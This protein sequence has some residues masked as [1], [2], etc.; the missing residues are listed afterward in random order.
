MAITFAKVLI[1]LF[2][3]FYVMYVLYLFITTRRKLSTIESRVNALE[4]QEEQKEIQERQRLEKEGLRQHQLLLQL[5]GASPKK[6]AKEE[7]AKLMSSQTE[8]MLKDF[9]DGTLDTSRRKKRI[10]W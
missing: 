8:Q 4:G 2:S 5:S 9:F 7:P 3:G 6:S 1:I 10:G